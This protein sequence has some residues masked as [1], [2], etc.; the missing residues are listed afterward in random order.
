M[1]PVLG[2]TRA[3]GA[4]LDLAPVLNSAWLVLLLSFAAMY[5]IIHSGGS[6]PHEHP[7]C[8]LDH[9]HGLRRFLDSRKRIERGNKC[10]GV[11]GIDGRRRGIPPRFC[12]HSEVKT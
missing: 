11:R 12:L 10:H 3:T 1:T 2:T 4:K 9:N 5:G 7:A 8:S 6:P